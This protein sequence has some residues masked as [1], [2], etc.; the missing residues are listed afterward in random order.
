MNLLALKKG[1]ATIGIFLLLP[2]FS[3]ICLAGV[4]TELVVNKSSLINLNK[5]IERVSVG[6]PAIAD[7]L[8]ISPSQIQVTGLSTGATTLIVWEKGEPKASFFDVKVIGDVGQLEPQLKEMAPNDAITV[9]F[10]KDTIVLSGKASNEQTI[11]KAVS[12]AQAYAPKILN[13]IRVDNPN[14]VLLQV[15]VAQVDKTALKKLGISA[16]LK[17]KTAEGFSNLVGAPT[18]G[19]STTSSGGGISGGSTTTSSGSGTGIA[20]NVQALGSF[21]PLDA[22]QIGVSYFPAGIGA[23]LQAL[24]TKGLAKILAEPNLLVKSGQEGKFHAGSKIPYNVL[25]STGGVSTPTIIFEKVG[26]TLN[27]KPEVMENGLIRLKID[28]AEVSSIAGTLTVNGY[29]IID[30]RN[31]N[32]DVELRDGESLI[33][34]GLL[35]ED[36]I[37]TMSKIPLLGDIPILGALFRSTQ[38]ELKEKELVFF[39]TPKLVKP[40]PPGTKTELPTDK[41]PTPEQEKELKW[42]PL[43]N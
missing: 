6:N 8:V 24:S 15:K 26:I 3:G 12:I 10:A 34:A 23:V 11:A 27:F 22:F 16:F 33:L 42:M 14:Q 9:E 21:N 5:P 2:F 17:G 38:D 39:I 31:V 28:P 7:L 29:P 32:T 18:G 40:I 43:G 20:G 36:A 30:T 19:S 37:K 35:Q 41:A 4:P 13:H 1:L 25:V